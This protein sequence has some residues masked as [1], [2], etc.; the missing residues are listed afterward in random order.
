MKR[1]SVVRSAAQRYRFYIYVNER[2]YIIDVIFSYRLI[3]VSYY[4]ILNHISNINILYIFIYYITLHYII[5][6]S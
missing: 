2:F 3:I 5:L 6:E 4:V 1:V